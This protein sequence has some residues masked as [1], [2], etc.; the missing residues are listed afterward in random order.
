ME[1]VA[2][3][4]SGGRT[5]LWRVVGFSLAVFARRAGAAVAD[6]RFGG[7]FGCAVAR[8]G[9]F[10]GLPEEEERFEAGEDAGED[11][12]DEGV[13]GGGQHSPGRFRGRFAQAGDHVAEGG[14]VLGHAM[15]ITNRR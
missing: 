13:Q 11:G 8:G 12:G 3:A 10:A 14:G 7:D 2:G 1:R 15:V 5:E 6:A 9:A 4:D